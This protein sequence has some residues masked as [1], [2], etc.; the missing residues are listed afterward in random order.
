MF[1]RNL[2]LIVLAASFC[3][4]PAYAG[5]LTLSS[6]SIIEGQQL[7]RNHVF[8]GLGCKGKNIA[9]DLSWSGAPKETQSFAITVY[10]PDAPTGS[11]WWHWFAFNI[12]TDINTLSAGQKLPKEI[13]QLKNDYGQSGFGGACPP[14]GEVHRY[15]F[16]VHA[17]NVKL[18]LNE[19]ASNAHAG[20][21]VN[22]HSIDSDTITA[23]YT[24]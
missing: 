7:N 10:D 16:T 11:G 1:S 15:Q 18:K 17:L 3:G 2:S 5:S 24:R 6:K 9:P 13:V 12:P 14:V 21:L 22:A 4:F 20:Y 23:V 8:K 19:L